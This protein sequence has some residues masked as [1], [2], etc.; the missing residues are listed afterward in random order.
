MVP[1]I[2]TDYQD[3]PVAI[4]NLKNTIGLV[5]VNA[6]LCLEERGGGGGGERQ[7]DRQTETETDR[8]T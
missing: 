4:I 8:Q 3:R 7:T 6:M 2:I 1:L 5:A